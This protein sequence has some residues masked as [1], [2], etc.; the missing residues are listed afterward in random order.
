MRPQP[1]VTVLFIAPTNQ[2]RSTAWDLD[3]RSGRLG[4]RVFESAGQNGLRGGMSGGD[5]DGEDNPG[6][7]VCANII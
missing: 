7:N 2:P 5:D 4:V 3:G 6:V 1:P